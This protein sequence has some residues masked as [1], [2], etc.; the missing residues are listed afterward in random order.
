MIVFDGTLPVAHVAVVPRVLWVDDRPYRSGYV[1][2]VATAVERQ[3]EGFGSQAIEAATNLI[4]SSYEMGALS[5]GSHDFYQ[6]FGWE[7]WTGPSFVRAGAE[8]I[9]TPD[10]DDGVMVLRLGP[11][12][13]ADLA[14]AIACERRSGDDW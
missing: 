2:G 12:A 13:A 1:E 9:R 6:R 11:G 3:R 7:R 14:A 5:T 8:L 10:E 4:R